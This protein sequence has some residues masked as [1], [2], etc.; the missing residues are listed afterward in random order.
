MRSLVATVLVAWLVGC[1]SPSD[2]DAGSTAGGAP[3]SGG[4]AGGAAGGN[5]GGVNVGGGNAS[6]GNAG[7]GNAG[8][9]NAGGGNAGGGNVSDAG[10]WSVSRRVVDAGAGFPVELLTLSAP[11]KELSYA[12]WS[13]VVLAD[14]GVAP[15]VVLTKPYDGI[16]WTGDARDRRWSMLP[17]GL[18]PDVDGPDSGP[19]PPTIFF[20][21]TTVEEHAIE[22]KLY[23]IHG[24][25]TLAVFG[26]FYAGGSIQNDVDDMVNGFE[27]LAREPGVDRRRIG[28]FGGSWGGFL[29]VYGAAAAPASVTPI[30]GAAEFPLTDFADEWTYVSS[31]VPARLTGV[32]RATYTSFFD[33]YL[34]RISATTHGAPDAGGDFSR[35]DLNW[36]AA[37]LR[38]PFLATHE[39]WDVLVNVA[40]TERLGARLPSLVSPL[41]L[42][43]DAPPADWTD[44]GISHG[45][46]TSGWGETALKTFHWARL[47]RT[48]S[49][50]HLVFVPWTRAPFEALLQHA[51]DRTRAGTRHDEVAREL[52]RLIDQRVWMY[53]LG[54]MQVETGPAFVS[55][56]VNAVWGLSTT[57]SS[58]A[59]VLDAGLPP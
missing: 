15:V 9:G 8:G 39:D 22:A 47:L 37:N 57:E 2:G 53:E 49:D 32:T 12:Q 59:T 14:G 44:G 41:Y 56:E 27:F 18:Q 24:I 23:R 58:I 20:Q 54:T 55:R 48:L 26:R 3:S 40:Q 51:R 36:V 19:N 6:G 29:A 31:V 11:G 50:T 52:A 1:L 38:T 21:P 17:G 34:R 10:A 7:G 42:R 43:H 4:S 30:V 35:F 46:L 5:V 28:I 13:P 16:S 33:P 45:V 25:S